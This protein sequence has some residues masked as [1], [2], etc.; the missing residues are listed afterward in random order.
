MYPE[1]FKNIKFTIA[2]PFQ[3]VTFNGRIDGKMLSPV[4][5]P[6]GIKSDLPSAGDITYMDSQGWDAS[7]VSSRVRVVGLDQIIKGITSDERTRKICEFLRHPDNIK[8]L[9]NHIKMSM[10]YRLYPAV[11]DLNDSNNFKFLDTNVSR[12]AGL[13]C[14]DVDGLSADV[15][16]MVKGLIK[17]DP[18]TFIG[19]TSPRGNGYKWM[20][21]VPPEKADHAAHYDSLIDYY[22]ILFLGAVKL[23]VSCRNINRTIFASH[24]ADCYVNTDTR[25]WLD[26]KERQTSVGLKFTV[27]NT[28]MAET[29][30][31]AVRRIE[32]GK[33]LGGDTDPLH[34]VD[35]QKHIFLVALAG[36]CKGMGMR[37]DEFRNLASGYIINHQAATS[38]SKIFQK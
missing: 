25:V 3:A 5:H 18:H 32:S 10:L 2:P 6:I 19:F 16:D 24:D 8:P 26:K 17:S 23:D 38:V 34:F 22:N 12:Y 20:V 31:N 21:R 14:F 11:F 15:L 4:Y 7:T 36:M 1:Y 27:S 13:L 35:G 33:R 37:E 9:Q 29:F 28:S 30:S